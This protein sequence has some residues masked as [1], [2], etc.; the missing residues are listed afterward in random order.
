[1]FLFKHRLLPAASVA[2]AAEGQQTAA[3]RA[4]G[5]PRVKRSR[6]LQRNTLPFIIYIGLEF[7]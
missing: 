3:T 4:V 5:P 7:F 2:E 6:L 1:M